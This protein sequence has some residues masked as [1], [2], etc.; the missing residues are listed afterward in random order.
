MSWKFQ[1]NSVMNY[2]ITFPVTCIRPITNTDTRIKNSLSLHQIVCKPVG[3]Q[4][5]NSSMEFNNINDMIFNN[6]LPALLGDKTVVSAVSCGRI[7]IKPPWKCLWMVFKLTAL[8]IHRWGS[9]KYFL[10]TWG[11]FW[12]PDIVI[13]CVRPSVG[14]SPSLSAR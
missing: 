10:F 7:S 9:N 8:P 12:P 4:L 3:D 1:Q 5:K 6:N 11:K 2:F 13:A 14:Q